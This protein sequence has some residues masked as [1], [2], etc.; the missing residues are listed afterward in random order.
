[1]LGLAGVAV[2]INPLAGAAPD[3][4][5]SAVALGRALCWAGY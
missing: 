2:L 1:V 3:L 4:F 5:A